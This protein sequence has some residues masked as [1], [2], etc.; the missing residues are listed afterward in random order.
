MSILQD[1]GITDVYHYTPLHYLPLI[2]R[3]RALLSKPLIRARG[4]AEDH[5]RSMSHRHDIAR[6][7]GSYAFLTLHPAPPILKAKLSAGFPHIC[8]RIPV[9]AVDRVPFDLCRFNV[10]MTRRLRR[11]GKTGFPESATNGRYYGDLEIPIARSSSDKAAM[12]ARYAG[13]E[14]MIEV[15]IPGELHLPDDTSILCFSQQDHDLAA[16]I[17][18]AHQLKWR[19]TLLGPP[20]QY[21]R[22]ASYASSVEKFV[23]K[24]LASTSWS[25]DGLEFDRV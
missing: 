9:A 8:I 2:A 24:A 7:F 21:V 5:F 15:L 4:F 10:A 25:G 1:A 20:C 3:V 12:L 22:R 14:A 17:L 13:S 19:L 18:S 16:D 6:G 11:N 23:A